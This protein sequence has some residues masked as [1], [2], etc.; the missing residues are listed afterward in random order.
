MMDFIQYVVSE[1]KSKRLSKDNALALI[2]EYTVRTSNTGKLSVIHPLLHVNTS[3]LKQQSYSS[4][5]TGRE[6]YLKDHQINMHGKQ[7]IKI[8]PGVAYLEMALVSIEQALPSLTKPSILELQ[9]IIWMHPVIVN[10]SKEV[11]LALRANDNGQ[12]DFEIYSEEQGAEGSLP[13]TVHCRGKADFIVDPAPAK[14]NVEQLKARMQRGEL[15]STIIYAAYAKMGLQYGPTHQVIN[16]IFQGEDQLLAQLHLS[17]DLEEESQYLLHPGLTD[18][19]LQSTI[20]LIDDINTVSDKPS[21]P[22]TLEKIRIW[23]ACKRDMFVWVRY[24]QSSKRED[25]IIKLDLDLCD[26]EGNVC[27]QIQ[28]FSSRTLAS[29]VT[30]SIT[31]GCLLAAPVWESTPS[32]NANEL[33]YSQ[34]H[35]ILYDLPEISK[36]QIESKL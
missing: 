12:I 31:S 27:A 16:T 18:G 30:S 13:E 20:G 15:N 11:S 3:N 21:V 34:H 25:K 28:G 32:S 29:D 6:S 5:F 26:G 14:V 10:D 22:F 24:S 2:K 19:A 9:D 35:I 36:K 23:S 7:G 8:L 17:A 33:E 4:T 1:L